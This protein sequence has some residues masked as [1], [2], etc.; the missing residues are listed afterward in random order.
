M[1]TRGADS[2]YTVDTLCTENCA[3]ANTSIGCFMWCDQTYPERGVIS[4]WVFCASWGFSVVHSWFSF[5]N[6]LF[7]YTRVK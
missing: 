6:L 3:Q 7:D 5:I 1:C 2:V 4:L